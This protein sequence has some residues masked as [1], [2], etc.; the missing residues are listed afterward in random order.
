ME[1]FEVDIEC[2]K[3]RMKTER[4]R[5]LIQSLCGILQTP[6]A[7]SFLLKFFPLQSQEGYYLVDIDSTTVTKAVT[8]FNTI[9]STSTHHLTT[10]KAH[11]ILRPVFS[12]VT[13]RPIPRSFFAL[14]ATSPEDR[15]HHLHA[16]LT[17]CNIQDSV[18]LQFNMVK[19]VDP[20]DNLTVY[21][22]F[23]VVLQIVPNTDEMIASTSPSR[24]ETTDRLRVTSLLAQEIMEHG[25][26]LSENVDDPSTNKTILMV[27]RGKCAHC[28]IPKSEP[29]T[30]LRICRGCKATAYCDTNCQQ[31]DWTKHRHVCSMRSEIAR[32]ISLRL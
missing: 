21:L 25:I 28:Q 20:V 29:T 16:M 13:F 11:K 18:T 14:L 1:R 27:M 15:D 7:H 12:K 19:C 3:N 10:S 23:P 22:S 30:K 6:V 31:K 32:H 5:L 9:I 24:K 26:T 17:K 8:T 2:H 4:F